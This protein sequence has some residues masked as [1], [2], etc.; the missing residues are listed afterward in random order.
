MTPSLATRV[1]RRA[2]LVTA[3][4]LGVSGIGTGVLLHGRA[5]RALTRILLSAAEAHTVPHDE[6]HD[7]DQDGL[8]R[9]VP[10]VFLGPTHPAWAWRDDVTGSAE[11][12]ERVRD[13]VRYL[14][15]D[16][17]SRFG[18]AVAEPLP[19]R[20]IVAW[21]SD[22][23]LR[24]SVGPFALVYSLLALGVLAASATALRP[25][26][27]AALAPVAHAADEVAR[28]VDLSDGTRVTEEGPA[29]IRSLL[30]AVNALL[31]RLDVA[32]AA[33]SRFTADAAHELRTPV[34]ALLGHIE[35]TLRRARAPSDY[36]DALEDLHT[37][38]RH[39][40]RLV[41]SLLDLAR[42]DAGGGRR[43][44]A[45]TLGALTRAAI[46]REA[47]VLAHAGVTVHPPSEDG[48]PV[49]VDTTLASAAIANL[50]RNVARHAPG[51][52]AHL[53]IDASDAHVVLCVDDDGPGV[54]APDRERMFDR[55]ARQG[56]ARDGLGLGLPLAREIA[57]RHGGDCT[58]DTSP[59]GG[60]RVR[61][62]VGR[63]S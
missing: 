41:A 20:W 4:A 50:L 44:A 38:A 31:D 24:D 14:L 15:I 60:T 52:T 53:A 2:L 6:T 48:P 42:V 28:V 63:F 43:D 23:R 19:S 55:F 34:T 62:S 39:L 35:V 26:I 16:V 29:E 59:S 8:P 12:V 57:R 54:A 27:A 33:Q 7:L 21:A 30:R 1:L 49:R 18:R 17:P 61:W 58:L 25:L 10:V 45:H 13:G 3:V 22:V 5:E 51:S 37:E 40:S 9:A 56:T 36:V 47:D 32:F 11:P 46:D